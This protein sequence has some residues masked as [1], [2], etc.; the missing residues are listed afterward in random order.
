MLTTLETGDIVVS[1]L[2]GWEGAV[3]VVG[4]RFDGCCVSSEYPTFKADR[5]RLLP[6]FFGGIARSSRFWDALNA[7]ARGSM[8][9]RRRINSAEFLGVHIWLPPIAAQA[10]AAARLQAVDL[11]AASR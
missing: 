3:A 4:P 10:H 1:K 6:A 9:R 5:G 7:G 8:V 11:A 2:N